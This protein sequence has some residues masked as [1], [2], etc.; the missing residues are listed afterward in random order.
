M[1]TVTFQLPENLFT[2]LQ[3]TA[4]ATR[5]PFNEVLL[6]AIQI[7]NP[8]LRD[9]APPEFQA[10]L[11]TLDRTDD[12]TLWDIAHIINPNPMERY[13]E[14]L[15]KNPNDELSAEERDELTQLR[16]DAD[17]LMLR[18]AQAAALLWRGHLVPL[19][20]KLRENL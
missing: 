17:R 11:A 5:R 18:K 16:V 6:R 3:Q 12:N 19:A 14:L 9:N 10:D 8:P 13:Q 4:Q 7:G 1:Q 2:R 20:E 15:D